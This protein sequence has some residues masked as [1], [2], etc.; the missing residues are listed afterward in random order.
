ME[1]VQLLHTFCETLNPQLGKRMKMTGLLARQV[2]RIAGCDKELLDQIEMAGMVHD[3][4]LLG[5]PKG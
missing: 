3:I 5:L 4:G 1:A 2:A